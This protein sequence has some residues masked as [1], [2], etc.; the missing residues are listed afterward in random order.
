MWE[1]EVESRRTSPFLT[2]PFRLPAAAQGVRVEPETVGLERVR[3]GVGTPVSWTVTNECG[4]VTVVP[5]GGPL[6][7]ARSERPTIADGGSATHPVEVPAGTSSLE[8][9]IGNP[10]DPAADF[11][12]HGAARH[13]RRGSSADG[14]SEESVTLT[15]PAPGTYTVRVEGY[16][17]PGGTT[18]YDY[19]DVFYDGSLGSVDVPGT[20]RPLPN[21]AA[22]T[23]PG[24]VTA[25]AA[26]TTGR[27]LF[28]RCGCALRRARWSAGRR[29]GPQGRD[30]LTRLTRL[31][32]L[33]RPG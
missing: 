2:N 29:A 20:P 14:D 17:V 5:T 27:Q 26:P 1:I 23:V 31:T 25:R 6:G 4:P 33:G 8:V 15:R 22:V 12:P 24:T 19:R 11:D 13:R 10:G 7:S 21:G 32:R 16:A 30:R 18:A 28:G 9:A 3:A